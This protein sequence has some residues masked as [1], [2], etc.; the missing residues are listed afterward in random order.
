LDLQ[1]ALRLRDRG[2]V[3]VLAGGGH[4]RAVGAGALAVHA[5]AGG[6]D[7][8][9]AGIGV[10]RNEVARG[11]SEYGAAEPAQG[12]AKTAQDQTR[13]TTRE[14]A[15]AAAAQDDVRH[16][17]AGDT[18]TSGR[19]V[20]DV[21]VGIGR[22]RRVGRGVAAFTPGSDASAPVAALVAVAVGVAAV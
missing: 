17:A 22:G 6:A 14:A 21:D 10:H 12:T 19:I 9:G 13:Q 16:G 2:V 5:G 18:T 11:R 15:E 20:D 8:I 4:I 3:A 1:E 7:V